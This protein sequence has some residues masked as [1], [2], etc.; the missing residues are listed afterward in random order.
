MFQAPLPVVPPGCLSE[1][2]DTIQDFTMKARA[3]LIS[4]G[5]VRDSVLGNYLFTYVCSMVKE[6]IFDSRFLNRSIISMFL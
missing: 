1:K 6:L 5:I 4:V 2:P 3:A